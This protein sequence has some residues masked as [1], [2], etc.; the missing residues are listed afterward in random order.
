MNYNPPPLFKQ[1]TSARVKVFLFSLIAILL[2]VT[3]ARLHTLYMVRQIVGS[4][5]YPLQMVA[6]MPRDAARNVGDYFSQLS[7]L[8]KENANFK[9][10]QLA[11]AFE[12]Q[13]SQQ[14]QL[15][16]QQLRLLLG[17]SEQAPVK[18]V[19]ATILY[20]AR[21]N[22][23][24]RIIVNRGLNNGV[25]PGQPVIDDKGVVGQVNRVFPF[26]SEVMLLT[27]KDQVIPIQVQR[28][29]LRSIVY[30]KGQINN[31]E[32][33]MPGKTD[34]KAGDIL[35]TSGIDGIYPPGLSVARVDLVE[36]DATS[37][38]ERIICS[39]VAGLNRHKEVLILL[40]DTMSTARPPNTEKE[41]ENKTKKI[42][43]RVTRDSAEL[44][45]A[46]KTEEAVKETATGK[47]R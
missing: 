8:E 47:T 18:S 38:F 2:L 36:N 31:L 32:M 43:R 10:A 7:T 30:G 1:G 9:R 39:P 15:D 27:D 35:V 37:T 34:I 24:R 46:V 26:T 25:A 19:M 41:L 5:L 33:R 45:A 29:G 16:N 4:A 21:D 28:N 20:D 42:N 12:V 44:P 14:L 40:V 13:Q 22:F 23:N 11:H 3:D 17:A 6:L